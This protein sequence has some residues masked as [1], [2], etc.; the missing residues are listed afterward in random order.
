MGWPIMRLEPW[1]M[2]SSG[3]SLA[4]AARTACST[5]AA[6]RGFSVSTGRIRSLPS[7]RDAPTGAGPESIAPQTLLKNGF[8]ARSRCS[9]PGMTPF[10]SYSKPWNVR[11][12][13]LA[14]MHV[15]AP[16]FGATVQGGKNLA[17][18]EEA[19]RVEG[20]FDSLLLVEVDLG[21]HLAHQIAFLDTDA[22]LAGQNA[23][24]FDA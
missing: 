16:Q 13:E 5:S 1:P 15:H 9:R 10:S 14:G 24:E 17:R 12:R 11:E 3:C 23:A 18:I 6:S 4:M 7:F 2:I 8:R 19:L 20:A 21:K 22:V